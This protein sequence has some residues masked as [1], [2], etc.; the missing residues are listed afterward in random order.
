MLSQADQAQQ[1]DPALKIYGMGMILLGMFFQG[2]QIVVEEYFMK[3]VSIP[4]MCIVGMEGVWGVIIV[5]AIVFP[6]A[7]VLPGDDVGGCQ[8]NLDNDFH[9]LNS[10]AELQKV[11]AIYLVSVFTY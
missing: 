9:M 5:F 4:P 1:V 3:G 7:R 8:E 11:V 10:S 2:G 6:I